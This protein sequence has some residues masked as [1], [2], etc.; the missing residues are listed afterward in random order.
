MILLSLCLQIILI[1]FGSIRKKCPNFLIRMLL[2]S[3]YTSADLV[4][5]TALGNMAR[6]QGDVDNDYSKPSRDIQAF[7]VPFILL[8]LGGPDTITAYSLEDNELWLRHFLVLLIQIGIAFYVFIRSWKKTTLTFIAIPLFVTGIIKYLERTCVL[9]SSSFKHLRNSLLFKP[10]IK[11]VL[12]KEKETEKEVLRREVKE[13]ENTLLTHEKVE[14]NSNYL[15]QAYYLFKRSRYLFAELILDYY[16][17]VESYS[18]IHN[19]QPSDVFKLIEI[20]LGF[21]YDKLYTKASFVY[22]FPGIFLRLI[23]FF[24]LFIR[25]HRLFS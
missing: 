8:H 14:P 18:I 4:A 2:W 22:S 20:E 7:W 24:F 6:S 19:K 3:A 17:R 21:M 1:V 10:Q 11:Y 25:I 13:E 23:C 9:K 16:E 15:C 5:I 12:V